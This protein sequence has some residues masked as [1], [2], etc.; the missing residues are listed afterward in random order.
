[1]GKRKIAVVDPVQVAETQPLRLDLGCGPHPQPG[2]LGVDALSFD[3]KVDCVVD[4]AAG[5]WPWPDNSIDEARASHFLE[6]LTNLDGKW[7]RVTFFNELHRVLKPGAGCMITIPHWASVRYYGDPT[8]KEPFSEFGLLYLTKEWREVNAPH[9]DARWSAHGYACDF[10]AFTN[11]YGLHQQLMGRNDEYRMH[12]C[13]FFR[14][15]VTD[16]VFTVVKR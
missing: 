1:M 7:E 4:L 6:H 8:H 5:H 13:T 12:A 3:G 2:F 15:A 9:A 10:N 14:D 16:W 11:H